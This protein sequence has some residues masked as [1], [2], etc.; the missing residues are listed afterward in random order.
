MKFLTFLPKRIIQLFERL[1]KW[2]TYHL[3]MPQDLHYQKNTRIALKF[4]RQT[5]CRLKARLQHNV[6]I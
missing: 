2:K 5:R 1:K 6:Q 4:A 3:E